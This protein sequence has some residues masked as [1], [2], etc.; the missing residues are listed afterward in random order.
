MFTLQLVYFHA[1]S[2]PPQCDERSENSSSTG[3]EVQP[4]PAS[5]TSSPGNG[6][7]PAQSQSSFTAVIQKGHVATLQKKVFVNGMLGVCS[8]QT[9]LGLWCT[10]WMVMSQAATL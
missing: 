6:A 2:R 4:L 9:S 10:G 7:T 5:G 8:V 3:T 1:L